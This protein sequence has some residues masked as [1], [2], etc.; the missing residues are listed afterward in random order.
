[1]ET[2]V[3]LLA[4]MKTLLVTSMLPGGQTM[5]TEEISNYPGFSSIKGPE[6]INNMYKQ[7]IIGLFRRP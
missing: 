7:A 4:K 6:L 5:M 3:D 1:M 2:L